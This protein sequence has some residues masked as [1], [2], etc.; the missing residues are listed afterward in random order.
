MKNAIVLPVL[1][2]LTK[3][4]AAY[5]RGS[6]PANTPSA[7]GLCLCWMD[8]IVVLNMQNLLIRFVSVFGVGYCVLNVVK[9]HQKY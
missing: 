9:N 2:L 1:A 4:A 8:R 6:F 3:E 7:D 5:C